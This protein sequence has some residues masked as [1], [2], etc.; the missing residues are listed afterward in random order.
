MRMMMKSKIHR[1]SVTEAN[2]DY[3]GSIT[4]DRTLMEAADIL[5]YE[6]VQVLDVT[7]GSRLETYAIEGGPGEIC[8]NGAAAHLVQEGDTVIIIT[9]QWVPEE[10]AR[11]YHPTKVFVDSRNRIVSSELCAAV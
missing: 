7:N 11:E 4:I 1:A 3:E 10:E 9:Y 6:K 5:P 8:I 2:L